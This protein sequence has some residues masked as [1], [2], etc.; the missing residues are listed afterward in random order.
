MLISLRFLLIF[1]GHTGEEGES[2]FC[3]A[4]NGIASST[5]VRICI[6]QLNDPARRN[7]FGLHVEEEKVDGDEPEENKIILPCGTTLLW[8][9]AEFLIGRASAATLVISD[10]VAVGSR[11]R[12]CNSSD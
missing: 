4:L 8:M 9:I 3:K 1:C 7:Q 11:R 6:F 2:E 10:S 5:D 12:S